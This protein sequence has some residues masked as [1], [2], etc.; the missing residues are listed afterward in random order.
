M[1]HF[2]S[3]QSL[4]IFNQNYY[5]NAMA[6]NCKQCFNAHYQPHCHPTT[7]S[8]WLCS[9]VHCGPPHQSRRIWLSAEVHCNDVIMG[10]IASQITSLTIVF[11]T[12][13][14]DT[15]RRKHQNS[16]SLAFVRGIHRRPV[17]S[18]H[19]WPVTRKVFPFDDIIML[20]LNSDL[21]HNLCLYVKFCVYVW[22]NRTENGTQLF[23]D[24]VHDTLFYLFF[25]CFFVF[26]NLSI[27]CDTAW[28]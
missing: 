8:L 28:S 19:K 14:L 27:P 5:E 6:N 22:Y 16:A 4:S 26:L 25:I 20:T 18:P 13:Y 24:K 21:H 23:D 2:D 11:S 9:S 7:N 10:A 17:N 1:I 12:V 3:K 15:D